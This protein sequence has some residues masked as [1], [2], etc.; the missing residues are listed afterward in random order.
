MFTEN[1]R[2][3]FLKKKFPKKAKLISEG[4]FYR[5]VPIDSFNTFIHVPILRRV[6][7]ASVEIDY[8]E[9]LHFDLEFGFQR[10]FG[11]Y[12]EYRQINCV[13]INKI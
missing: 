11:G 2:K 9:E 12:A 7:I 3:K 4:G 8:S 6:T 1:S 10:V 13:R 5:I